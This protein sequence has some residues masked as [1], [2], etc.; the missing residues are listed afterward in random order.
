MPNKILFGQEARDAAIRGLSKVA[1]AVGSTLGPKASNVA[2]AKPF[3]NVEVTHDGVTV[4]KNI[5]LEDPFEDVGAQLIREAAAKTNDVAGD[6]TTTATVLAE[7]IVLEADKAIKSGA[8]AQVIKNGIEKASELVL[9]ELKR[10]ATPV[11]TDEEA[12]QVATISA[13][14]EYLGQ[15]VA[16]AIKKA[17]KDG[18]V[19]LNEVPTPDIAIEHTQGL[20]FDRGFISQY[21]VTDDKNRAMIA[22]PYILITDKLIT[23]QSEIIPILET[24]T[25]DKQS[26][27]L[28]I[29]ADDVQGEALATLVVNK[30]KGALNVVAV[31]APAFG[32]RRK[33]ILEDIAVLTGATVISEDTGRAISTVTGSDFGQ[34]ERVEVQ[35]DETLIV[36]G[37][38]D[39]D[40]LEARIKTIKNELEDAENEFDKDIVRQRLAKLTSGVVVIN[41]GGYTEVERKQRQYRIEDAVNATQCAIEEGIV[42][43]GETA[44]MKASRILENMS[45]PMYAVK[46]GTVDFVENK[47]GQI[48]TESPEHVIQIDMP[49]KGD[50]LTGSEV[51]RKAL[52]A[53]FLKLLDNAGI[54]DG[55]L[56]AKGLKAQNNMG[57]DVMKGEIVDLLKEGVIDPVKVSRSALMNAVSVACEILTT[58]CLVVEGEKPSA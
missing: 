23:Q 15:I 19:T 42:A 55:E 41:V 58:N 12:F 9:T 10:M 43:G 53:P 52:K 40:Q 47:P 1:S 30:L 57:I 24:L 44:L 49:I 14:S 56:I 26:K 25:K 28:C 5:I 54:V 16:D 51:L 21:F 18:V 2:I 20:S 27:E 45:Y 6:G 22:N 32:L 38:G 46:K 11:K 33:Q 7:A 36:N 39:F 3:M 13:A 50:E 37:K 34:C 8:N 31:K 29:I 35:K 48:I 4:A 17:G